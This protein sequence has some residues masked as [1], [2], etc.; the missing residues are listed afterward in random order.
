[1]QI[2]NFRTIGHIGLSI[3][4]TGGIVGISALQHITGYPAMIVDTA[5]IVGNSVHGIALSYG[6]F[7]AQTE[8]PP[9][10]SGN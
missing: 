10:K 5:L 3:V 8:Q 4:I 6:S 7:K 9:V 1:M 2:S